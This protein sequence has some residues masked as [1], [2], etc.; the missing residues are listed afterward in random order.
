ME[1]G[2]SSVE[3]LGVKN[4][5][6]RGRRVLLTGHTGFKGSW[7]ALLLDRLGAQVLGVSLPPNT[8]PALYDV[9]K[10]GLKIDSHLFDLRDNQ[11]LQST[12][13]KFQPEVVL[14]LAAQA[15][16]QESYRDPVE[17][18]SVNLMATVHVL[19]ACRG[20]KNLSSVV[21]VTSDKCY[22]NL[23]TGQAYLETDRL[24]GHDPYSASKACAEIATH[25]FRQSFLQTGA[26]PIGV[27]T[28]RAGNVIGGGDWSDNRLIPDL[29]RAHAQG[30]SLEIRSPAAV[31]PW[32]HV[33]EPIEGYL[34]LA[35][36]LSEQPTATAGAWNFGPTD[37]RSI[38]TVEDILKKSRQILGPSI[39]W[40]VNPSGG[41][42]AKILKLNS[43]KAQEKLGWQP[44]WSIDTSLEKTLLWYQTHS[45]DPTSA[46]HEADRQIAQRISRL[47][48]W[49]SSI[50]KA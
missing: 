34:M 14:H 17:T 4:Q 43:Q 12:I 44:L 10:D 50:G 45:Q 46:L 39:T 35:Q 7:L 31:R 33:L 36:R 8:R 5:F 24:G 25:S 38:C 32:Q 19:E 6:W 42:E 11:R 37:D 15:L 47:E 3:N 41:H 30:A 21:V 20:L 16:V 26:Q 22:E 13:Q 49:G 23:E 27:A 9:L 29:M 18:F 1:V 48:N 2:P 28:A 40:H